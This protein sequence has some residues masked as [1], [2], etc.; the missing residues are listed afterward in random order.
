[1]ANA[2]GYRLKTKREVWK[3]A[4]GRC[5][6][7]GRRAGSK[8]QTVDHF[9]PQIRGGTWDRR[10]LAPLCKTCN[11]SRGSEPVNPREYYKY[12]EEWAIQELL[13]YE[14]EFNAQYAPKEGETE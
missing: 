13:E 1:M 3:K 5:A 2:K 4:N 10:N 9:I 8:S 12:A 14:K 7:C 11:W 6:H